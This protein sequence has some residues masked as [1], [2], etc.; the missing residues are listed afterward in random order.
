MLRVAV[1]KELLR[2]ARERAGLTVKDLLPRFPKLELWE[3]EK[4]Q[5]TLKQVERFAKATYA[6]V[7]YLFLTEP[8]VEPIPLPDFRTVRNTRIERPSPNML[9]MIYVCQQRQSWYHEYAQIE[10]IQPRDFVNSVTLRHP[11]EAV[12]NEMRARLHFDLEARR[13]CSTW[14]EALRLFIGQAD[15]MGVL[16]MCTGVVM[17]NNH[18]A[19]DPDE[20]R[21]FAIVDDLAPLVF[22]NGADTK[23]AQMFTLAHE[24]A[25]IWLGQSALTDIGPVGEPDNDV[26]RWC[27]RVA[28]ELLVPLRILRNEVGD[29][30]LESLVQRL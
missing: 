21:G 26:E 3:D 2:W 10:G 28:A 22:I 6:P 11:V 12:A 7:G 8:P 15:A 18:R 19:L 9:E 30:S 20:F 17:N 4:E 1:R 23:A 27:N 24:L 29:E 13:R 14:T 16:V 25:H 5:P